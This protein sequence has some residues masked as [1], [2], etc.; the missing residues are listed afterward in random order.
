[1]PP[2][3]SPIRPLDDDELDERTIAARRAGDGARAVIGGLIA[4][5]APADVLSAAAAELERVAATLAP[6]AAK[7]RYDGSEGLRM[8]GD[9]NRPL[10]EHHP[11]CGP[12]N[13]LAPPLTLGG[14]ENGVVATVT[15]DL[16]HEGMPGKVHGGV[17]AAAFDLVLAAAAARVAG[18]PSPTGTL[19]MRFVQPTPLWTEL[20]YEGK[21]ERIGER[22]LRST[23]HVS[24][25]GAVCVEAEGIFIAAREEMIPAVGQGDT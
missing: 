7:S 14:D 16:R 15:Y 13:P 6:H 22:K 2:S 23:G 18:R 8:E 3:P 4:S 9:P 20:R 19:T 17:L 12:A 5:H 25:D 11:L 10:F 24:T 1:M 21:C